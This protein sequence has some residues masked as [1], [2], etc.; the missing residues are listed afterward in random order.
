MGLDFGMGKTYAF[1]LVYKISFSD[2]TKHMLLGIKFQDFQPQ[3]IIVSFLIPNHT[4]MGIKYPLK[5]NNA[6]LA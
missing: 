4:T 3:T 1:Y 6:V 2:I 5:D